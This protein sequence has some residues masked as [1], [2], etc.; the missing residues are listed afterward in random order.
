[1]YTRTYFVE[2]IDGLVGHEAVVDVAV[3]QFDTGQQGVVGIADVVVVFVAVL[4]VV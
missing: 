2:C 1:M 3:C 4:D